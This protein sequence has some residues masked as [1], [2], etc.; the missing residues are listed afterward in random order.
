MTAQRE[1]FEKDYYKVLGVA[2][3]A[4]HK[5]IT[6]A[7]RKLAKQYHP[8]ANPGDGAAEEKFKDASAAY[9]V[10]GDAEKRKEY[11]EVRNLA[12]SG[13][14][15]MGGFRPPGG[16]GGPGG[17][18]SSFHFEDLSDLFGGLFNAGGRG[19][20]ARHHRAPMRGDDL[21]AEIRLSFLDALNGVT[22]TVPVL[23]DAQCE[24]C[25]GS[26][27]QPGTAPKV[28][29][30]CGGAGV[31]NDNQGLFSF[32]RPCATC[33]ASGRKIDKPCTT[34]RGIG[35]VRRTREVKVRIPAGV[36][37]GARIRLQGRGAPGASGGTPGDLFVLVHVASDT[38]FGRKGKNLTL[39]VPVTYS[40]LALGGEIEV[41]TLNGRVK[42]RIPRGTATGKTLRVKGHG[43][44]GG[45]LLV[46]V[47]L[48][49]TEVTSPEERKLLEE[50]QTIQEKKQVRKQLLA[51]APKG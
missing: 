30:T 3:N 46:T 9:D 24:T 8:D 42:L 5:E 47:E 11:D 23:G 6:K 22:T 21:E 40:E 37:D 28:C 17:P 51:R 12:A 34:C 41:P 15:G 39:R 18:G 20:G 45:D 33:N 13:I 25:K 1:W 35:Q 7:Y 31:S 2:K 19:G 4:S 27:A 50:L 36:Q 14:G 26:G 32:S 48:A 43:S 10:L 29:P 16:A 44:G 38:T 49:D